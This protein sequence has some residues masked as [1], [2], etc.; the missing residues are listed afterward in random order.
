[1]SG[2]IYDDTAGTA[3]TEND[4]AAPRV[5][6]NRATVSV[7][8][9]GATRA[10]YATVT[11][12]NALKIDGSAVTQPVSLAAAASAI[13]KAEDAASADLDVGVPAMAVRKASPANTS[14]NDG[15]YEMLQMS[16][17]RLWASATIDAA[18]PTGTNTVGDVGIKP[19]TTGGLTT[20][21]LVS[22]GSTNATVVKNSAG[23]LFG[24]YVYNSN[25]SMRKLAFHNSSSSPT[26]GASIFFTIN[27]PG[28]AAANVF[29][30]VGI[31]F[32]S[33]I[34]ITTVTDLA[35]NGT[36]AVSANDLTIN[37]FYA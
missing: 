5:S 8:E 23:Q 25:A 34:A 10:R 16:A 22:A 37:L 27:V 9:D 36:T 30:D 1:M 13:A 6:S 33:G 29:S 32:S 3:L 31:A 26:A 11:A 15:D 2:Y 4:A 14:G 19:R 18:L 21:H 17:G 20:Y 7:I 28:T 12:S 24:W 35:D